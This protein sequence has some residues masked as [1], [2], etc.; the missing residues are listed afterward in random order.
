M[1]ELEKSPSNSK[2]IIHCEE[3]D[4]SDKGFAE[5]IDMGSSVT[6]E[7]QGDHDELSQKGFKRDT[8]GNIMIVYMGIISIFWIVIL[9]LLSLD[10][11]GY[12]SNVAMEM[13]MHWLM[14]AAGRQR[15]ALWLILQLLRSIQ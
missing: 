1:V 8:I 2:E 9:L 3:K 5:H 10:Y 4:T 11:Y 14:P 7:E 6:E 13:R 15:Y 12:V